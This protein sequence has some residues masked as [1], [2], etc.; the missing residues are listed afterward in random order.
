VSE[1]PEVRA[2][3]AD[4]ER[5]VLALREHAVEGRLS[6]EEFIG[7]M[8]RAYDAQTYE[9]L[10]ELATDLPA[11]ALPSRR[12]PTRLLV[13]IFSS[14]E[15][16]GRLR[17][18]RRVACLST[19]GNIDLDLRQA[20]FEHDVITIFALG[21][22]CAMDVYVPES[23]EVDVRGLV[24]FG[25]KGANGEDP[26]PRPGTPLVRVFVFGTFAG[27]DVWR[28]PASWTR[29]S[30]GDVIRGIAAGGQKEL[31]A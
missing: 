7:R 4:R 21:T 8:E 28:V 13:S 2:S 14:T 18:G 20:T 27:I 6:L 3:D 1:T 16:Q 26:P 30:L 25:H 24:V 19:F 11:V 29:R 23:V 15:R 5:A 17:I 9:Q 22:F 10:A 31:G 12:R